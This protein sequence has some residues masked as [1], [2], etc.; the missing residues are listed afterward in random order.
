MGSNIEPEH[1]LIQAEKAL[2]RAFDVLAFAAVYRSK[3]VGMEGNDFLNTCC[4]F[5]TALPL[6]TI[7]AQLKA[8]ED[9]Q[10]RDRSKGSWQA[11][12]LDLDILM[13][14]DAVVDDDI[15]RY[16]HAFVPASE[17]V[18]IDLPQD[19]DGL[20]TKTSLMLSSCT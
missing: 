6:A 2:N 16:A 3:A 5:N 19:S 20:T 13:Y 15:Y 11:R 10:G 12:R 9:A 4:L 18:S 14:A 8:M 7:R 1:H 17:L